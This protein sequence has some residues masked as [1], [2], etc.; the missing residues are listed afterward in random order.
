MEFATDGT[1]VFP[2]PSDGIITLQLSGAEALT[3]SLFDAFGRSVAQG[4]VQRCTAGCV[5][6]LGKHTSGVYTLRLGET[7]GR[8][9][10]IVLE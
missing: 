10:K 1:A 8:C 4:R 6:D 3:W 7:A 5:V 2:N 9:L